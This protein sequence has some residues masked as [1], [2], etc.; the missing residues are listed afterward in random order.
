MRCIE[1]DSRSRLYL[2]GS[3]LIPTHNTTA[4]TLWQ[5]LPKEMI[6]KRNTNEGTL[7]LKN[8]SELLLM[9][10]DRPD[11]INNL[12]SLEINFAY[13]DQLEDISVE[14]WDTL[15][16]RIGR[17]SGATCRGGWP[18]KWKYRN[19]LGDCIPPRYLFASCYSPG[20]DHWIT[21]RF[22]ENGIE[23]ATYKDEGYQVIYGSTRDNLA[24]SEDYVKSRLRRGK[25]YVR[26]FV[27]ALDWGARE[28][29]IFEIDE[30][31]I[32]DPTPDLMYKIRHQMRLHRCMDFGE[33]SP[34]AC[35][36]FATDHEQNVYLYREYMAPNLTVSQHRAAIYELSKEDFP[37]DAPKLDYYSNWADP[38]IHDK[39]R[40]KTVSSGATY[41]VA[42]EWN[43][44]RIIDPLTAI[45]W[46]KAN[47][48]EAMT[49]NR[50]REYLLKD[51]RHKNP[52]TG[53]RGAPRL[54]FV[55]RTA[56][57]P[58]GAHEVLVDVRAAR[59][60]EVGTDADGNKLFGDKRDDKVRDHLLD[61]VAPDTRIL[62]WDMRYVR[63]SSLRAGDPLLGFDELGGGKTS[64]RQWKQSVVESAS[65]VV[66]PSYELTLEDGTV[67]VC[68]FDH[69]WLTV[70]NCADSV[71]A[72][73]SHRAWIRTEDLDGR[74]HWDSEVPR[75]R[76]SGDRRIL[77]PLDVWETDENR[78]AGYLAAAFDGEGCLSTNPAGQGAFTLSMAQRDN[79]MLAK[80][81]EELKRRGF[82]FGLYN[83][84][85]R[86]N[87]EVFSC[88]I[89]GGHAERL[90]FL[91]SIRP[92]R[93]LPKLASPL[94]RFKCTRHLRVVQRRFLGPTRLVSIQ[95]STRTF[96][97]EGLA[98]HNCVR[99]FI[100][101]RPALAYEPVQPQEVE[102]GHIVFSEY[103][104][105]MEEE[106]RYQ[107]RSASASFQGHHKI[108]RN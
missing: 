100:G 50:V 88:S 93:L 73:A 40:G 25:E 8:G 66:K 91:G 15:W 1:V 22:W 89:L 51:P 86:G 70:P 6:A 39:T 30:D 33:S 77:K 67:V 43:D 32:V 69:Q 41:S 19:R 24:L 37:P 74:G 57:Y 46:R 103:E 68:S 45:A 3:E 104:K 14:A 26:R 48:K 2:A 47:N 56:S 96:I 108:G 21:A 62:T 29:R 64:P 11:S 49:I 76:L 44:R 16:E 95:T 106:E 20:Y 85:T 72:N 31:S 7:T 23:R 5:L 78:G 60:E 35:C 54:Y 59:R 94:G 55:R 97:A 28:G 9:H 80:V 71:G 75:G 27:D 13:V 105:L 84:H 99:Y 81:T 92:H 79:E 36:W 65:T 102:P 10:L 18:A 58:Y 12:K 63:A 83:N 98:S 34:T 90:R 38:H 61:C 42:D 87:D 52:F 82:S 101:S 17:W 4:A 53:K 107:S